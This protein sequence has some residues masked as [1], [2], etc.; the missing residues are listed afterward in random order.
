MIQPNLRFKGRSAAVLA[1]LALSLVV[2]GCAAR[3]QITRIPTDT[4]TDLSGRWNDTDSREVSDEMIRDCL[5]G[6]WIVQH[7]AST[8][9]RPVAIVGRIQN[10]TLEHIPTGTFVADLERAMV[11]SG[12]VD[13]VA[14]ATERGALRAEKE[15]QWAN[16][17]ED[18]AKRM[19]LERGADY[20]LMGTVQS[21][22]DQ[23]GGTKVVFYQVD[24]TMVDIESNQ[25]VWIG[26]KKIKKEIRQA[27]YA[28]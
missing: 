15:D 26:Q 24:M 16:A 23:E 14:T 22:E 7:A 3:K 28:P 6:S 19:G 27:H 9:K 8:G 25:K 17:S 13:V 5:S 4:T 11:N 1:I 2:V 21:I 18:T 10:Q 20:M 12:K